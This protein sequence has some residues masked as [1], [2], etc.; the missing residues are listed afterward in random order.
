MRWLRLATRITYFCKLIGMASLAAF[1]QRELLWLA[2]ISKGR[3]ASL[4]Y[5][6]LLVLAQSIHQFEVFKIDWFVVLHRK[7][8]GNPGQDRH[9]SGTVIG[10]AF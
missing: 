4:F 9:R 1:L 2:G 6:W 7:V 8:S 3:I 10:S 5:G